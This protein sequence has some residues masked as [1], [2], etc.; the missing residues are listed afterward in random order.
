M[1]QFQSEKISGKPFK[2]Q[3]Y[4]GLEVESGIV[5]AVQTN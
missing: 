5:K 3:K 4:R 2:Y 1:F